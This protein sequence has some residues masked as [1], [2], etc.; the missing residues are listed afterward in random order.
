MYFLEAIE[1]LN[2]GKTIKS[3]EGTLYVKDGNFIKCKTEAGLFVTFM[4]FFELN[5][6][7]QV[8]EGD[9]ND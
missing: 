7:W 3:A 9:K 5:N 2:K 1:K 6:K 8:I 4:S